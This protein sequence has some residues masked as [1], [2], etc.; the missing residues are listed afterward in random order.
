MTFS[1]NQTLS[2]TGSA[3]LNNLD[4]QLNTSNGGTLTQAAGHTISGEGT[5]NAVLI[6]QGQV[7]ANL[8]TLSLASTIAN[9]GGTILA[10]GGNVQIVS[11]ATISGGTLASMG[12]SNLA[13]SS[14]SATLS[15]ITLSGGSLNILGGADGHGQQRDFQQRH[16]YRRFQQRQL[17]H[18]LDLQ[19]QSNA[20]RDRERG[21][22]R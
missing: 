1:G 6:N 19:R 21:P 9:A 7:E 14:G 13:L 4:A 5:I 11:G 22:Q 12:T 16:D 3:V 20:L 15:G 18:V 2:G 8:G 17:C 10:S